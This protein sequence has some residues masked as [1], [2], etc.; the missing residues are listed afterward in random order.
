MPYTEAP[1]GSSSSS[2]FQTYDTKPDGSAP[3]EK[4]FIKHHLLSPNFQVWKYPYNEV[5]V[6]SNFTDKDSGLEKNNRLADLRIIESRTWLTG[7]AWGSLVLCLLT[8]THPDPS[9]PLANGSYHS[10][11]SHLH[12]LVIHWDLE[13]KIPTKSRYRK[14]KR[15]HPHPEISRTKTYSQFCQC[16]QQSLVLTVLLQVVSNCLNYHGIVIQ[17]S[18]PLS[19][20]CG[21]ALTRE[22]RQKENTLHTVVLWCARLGFSLP[23]LALYALPSAGHKRLV[24]CKSTFRGSSPS[25][26]KEEY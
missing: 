6:P 19:D 9:T 24:G 25:P 20:Q 18:R 2:V 11:A 14:M 4:L 8:R 23:S 10:A 17:I 21:K 16:F 22:E 5:Y 12:C 15:P 7:K 26:R 13:K 3:E 1:G